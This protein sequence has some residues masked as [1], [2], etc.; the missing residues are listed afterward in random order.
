MADRLTPASET[1]AIHVRPHARNASDTDDAPGVGPLVKK[2][3]WLNQP[4]VQS[5]LRGE[6]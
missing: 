2:S 1:V 3:F 6:R 5:I 4:F